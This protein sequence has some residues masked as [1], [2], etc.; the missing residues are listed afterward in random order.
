[1]IPFEPS[2]PLE[3]GA[4]QSPR[5]GSSVVEQ[6]QPQRVERRDMRGQT[7]LITVSAQREPSRAMVQVFDVSGRRVCEIGSS[8]SLPFVFLWDGRDAGGRL[9]IPGIYVVACELFGLV[10]GNRETK[11]VVLGC[12]RR[13]Q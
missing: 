1:M 12:G 8:T 13:N 3:F 11:K 10:T 2:E 4:R 9:V 6:A 5:P 7:A